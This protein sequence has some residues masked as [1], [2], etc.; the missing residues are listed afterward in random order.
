MCVILGTGPGRSRQVAVAQRGHM[1]GAGEGAPPAAVGQDERRLVMTD[2][3][4][5]R[6]SCGVPLA[7][8]DESA[9]EASGSSDEVH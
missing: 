2:A 8:I 3:E 4:G 5:R 1:M 6:Y 7:A 9:A